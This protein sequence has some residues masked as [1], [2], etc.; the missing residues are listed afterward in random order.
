[1]RRVLC[2]AIIAR[3][4]RFPIKLSHYPLIMR[5]ASWILRRVKMPVLSNQLIPSEQNI[6]PSLEPFDHM[7]T[8][9]PNI[10]GFRQVLT[11]TQSELHRLMRERDA[12]VKRI[13]VLRQTIAGLV[14]IFGDHALGK[15][16]LDL[17]KPYRR[18]RRNGMTQI[19]RSVLARSSEP[20]T[21]H[22]LIEGI[23]ATDV[24]LI[25]RQ[26]N[27]IASVYSILGR[28]ASYGEVRCAV[29]GSGRR[30][31]AWTPVDGNG[32]LPCDP[33]ASKL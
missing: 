31:W 19:C 20:L 29:A 1:M 13:T 3:L 4:A 30:Q 10:P 22:E 8:A 2:D 33:S 12:I 17:L 6:S 26:K 21:A 28:L 14:E 7:A 32:R 11:L 16:H 25:Q 23:R 18:Q 15:E 5:L 24:T 9:P 27:P